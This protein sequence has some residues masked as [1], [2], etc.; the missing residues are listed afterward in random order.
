MA[1]LSGLYPRGP[2]DVGNWL[3]SLPAD[4]TVPFMPGWRWIATPGHTPGHISLFRDADK[5]LIAGDAFI[6]TNQESASAVALQK[7]EV[8]GPPMYY[9]QDWDQARASVRKLADLQ[10]QSVITGHGPPFDGVELS[11]ALRSLADNFD[12]IARP[13]H[14]RYVRE[15]AQASLD[16]TDYIP[17]RPGIAASVGRF[18][19]SR[20]GI[21]IL[22]SLAVAA[23]ILS[24][25]RSR[26]KDYR[27]R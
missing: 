27:C 20:F 24:G 8:H 4:G 5:T 26:K 22:A 6:T 2:I 16:G 17:P 18:V 1:A 7:P 14:G 21:G 23:L 11:A 15:P 10:P 13:K 9:T 19:G 3:L 12:A 25:R